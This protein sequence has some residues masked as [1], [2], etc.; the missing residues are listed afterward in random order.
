MPCRRQKLDCEYSTEVDAKTKY[1]A[2]KEE[3]A[4]LRESVKAST[5]LW[6]LLKQLS[7]ESY[8]SLRAY[9]KGIPDPTI[10]LH[11]IRRILDQ[12]GILHEQPFTRE[13]LRPTPSEAEF[14]LMFHHHTSYPNL[15]PI[16]LASI[17][18]DA[19]IGSIKAPAL[20]SAIQ[21]HPYVYP[22]HCHQTFRS[23]KVHTAH[24]SLRS[25][26][27]GEE[28]SPII[29]QDGAETVSSSMSESK[30]D[31]WSLYLNLSTPP[32]PAIFED[33]LLGAGPPRLHNEPDSRLKDL[34][35]AKW[36][37]VPIKSSEAATMI[38]SYF[39]SDHPLLGILDADLFIDDLVAHRPKFCS[40]MLVN[41]LL[42]LSSV[43]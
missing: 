15:L 8:I 13:I 14:K 31:A 29:V 35:I 36:S 39:Y 37:D 11:F 22:S 6:E 7:E 2:I 9:L 27:M 4:T 20:A 42:C 10:G 12:E 32:S 41:A 34:E 21:D 23:F 24:F 3:N 1:E 33:E 17:D 43:S 38:T 28:G 16:D 19:L 40:P 18:F 30:I 25:S 26:R 5:E